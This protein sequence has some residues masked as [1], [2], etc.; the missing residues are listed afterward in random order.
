ALA[1]AA[2]GARAVLGALRRA[3]AART[4]PEVRRGER[5]VTTVRREAIREG[6]TL[7]TLDRPERLNAMIRELVDDL[8]EALDAVEDDRECR[9]AILT[10]AGR[11]FCAGLDLKETADVAAEGGGGPP[12]A[13]RAQQHIASLVTQLSGLS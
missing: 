9:V 13:M 11:G 5:A 6:I 8:H 1:R 2:S 3:R 7:L 4:G 10:G 12:A